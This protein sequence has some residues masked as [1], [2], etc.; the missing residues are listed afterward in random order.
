MG[1]KAFLHRLVLRI[2]ADEN[3]KILCQIVLS[4]HYARGTTIMKNKYRCLEI[5]K[6]FS[7][8][9]PGTDQNRIVLLAKRL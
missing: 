8:S 1:S 2:N 3:K 9:A 7:F 6:F 4:L 5:C